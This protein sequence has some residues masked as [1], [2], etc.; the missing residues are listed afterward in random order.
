ME[1][2]IETLAGELQWIRSELVQHF[3][4]QQWSQFSGALADLAR[5]G[6]GQSYR[7]LCLRAQSLRELI[8]ERGGGRSFAAGAR[9]AELFNELMFHLS[10]LQWS[11]QNQHS[12]PEQNSEVHP[13]ISV[14]IWKEVDLR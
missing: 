9:V 8:G 13:Q 10:H 12:A 14:G 4:T 5:M 3:Q 2:P 7:E 11:T 6:E 1:E